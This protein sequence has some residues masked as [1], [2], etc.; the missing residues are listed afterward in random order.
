MGKNT[1]P[2]HNLDLLD[3]LRGIAAYAVIFWHWQH[4]FYDGPQPTDFPVSSQ[5]LFDYFSLFYLYGIQAVPLFFALSGVI[6]FWKSELTLANGS[7]DRKEFSVDRFSRLYPLHFATFLVVALLQ[8]V[9]FRVNG[10]YFVYPENDAHHALLNLLLIPAWG[11][12]RG[13]SFN[14]PAWSVSIELLL[15]IT[16]A[17]GCFIAGWARYLVFATLLL[18]GYLLPSSSYKI[19]E[20]LT[21]FYAAGLLFVAYRTTHTR[22]GAKAAVPFVVLAALSWLL[23]A[24]IPSMKDQIIGTILFPTNVVA[25]AAVNLCRKMR[26]SFFRFLGKISF[27]VYLW[28]FPIQIMTAFIVAGLGYSKSVFYS[29]VTLLAFIILTTVVSTISFFLFEKPIQKKIRDDF[30]RCYSIA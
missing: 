7:K 23:L 13:W 25:L 9:Y 10:N 17:L 24:F 27:A 30:K 16:F 6:F 1:L 11:L 3:G 20:G 22:F 26:L 2:T 4:F 5:P 8:F 15:Y 12:E 28:H 18:L 21:Q 14:A 29:P 19:A